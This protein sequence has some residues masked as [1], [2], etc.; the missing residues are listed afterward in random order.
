MRLGILG[1]DQARAPHH[2]NSTTLSTGMSDVCG[3][4]PSAQRVIIALEEAKANYIKYE[5]DP[6]NKPECPALTYG[7]PPVDPSNPSPESAKLTES[8]VLLEF[9]ADLYP[10][11][12][13]L[14][15]NPVER[16]H[17]RFIIDVF[18]TKVFDAF[19]GII[20]GGGSPDIVR[21]FDGLSGPAP[22]ASQVWSVLGWRK[23]NIAD[24]AV[25]PFL[26]RKKIYAEIFE[27]ERFGTLQKYT[28]ALL[29]RDTV[30]NSFPEDKYL[31]QVKTYIESKGKGK[32]EDVASVH[33]ALL[34]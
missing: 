4:C 11:S 3:T 12:G 26:A 14:S 18:H 22:S 5:V 27:N 6:W 24:A 15:A 8:L 30:K 9:I 29:S 17:A 7:G 25:A 34:D 16:A 13:L 23:I 2:R 21:W 32:A 10:D 33:F 19:Y 20:W 28:E 1:D 31:G